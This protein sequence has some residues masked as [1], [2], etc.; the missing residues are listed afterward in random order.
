MFGDIP[1]KLLNGTDSKGKLKVVEPLRLE[2]LKGYEKGRKDEADALH[3]LNQNTNPSTAI[4]MSVSVANVNTSNNVK[5]LGSNQ[6]ENRQS[7]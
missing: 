7:K 3:K 4:G 5:H 2:K 6:Y 1:G